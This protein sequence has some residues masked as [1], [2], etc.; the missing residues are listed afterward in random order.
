MVLQIAEDYQ[1][2]RLARYA[3]SVARAFN[4]FYE[5]ERVIGENGEV[6]P[7]RLALVTVF[8]DIFARVFALL[9]IDAP[10]KM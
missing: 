8:K 9:G 1:V 3:M 10:E 5:K 4:N 2:S 6:L 7:E